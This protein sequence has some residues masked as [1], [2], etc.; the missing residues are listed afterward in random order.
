[1]SNTPRA[2]LGRFSVITIDQAVAGGSN[3][4]IAVLAARILGVESFALF[5]IIF[6]VY[7]LAQ[8][9]SRGLIS[10]PL[11]IHPVESEERPSEVLGSGLFLGLVLGLL[12]AMAGLAFRPWDAQLGVGLLILA[13]FLPLL[14]LQDLGRYL[15]FATQRP[16]SALTLDVTW[17]VLVLVTSGFLMLSGRDSLKWF[18]IGW[19]ASGAAAGSLLVWKHRGKMFTPSSVWIRLTWGYSWRYLMAYVA[20]QGA[21]LTASIALR[22][23]AGARVLGGVLGA[24]LLIRPY[25]TFETAAIA[26]GVTEISR[27]RSGVGQINAHVYRTTAVTTAMALASAA[28]MV[29]LPDAVGRVVLGETW[30]EAEKYMVPAGISIIVLALVSGARAGLLGQ[31]AI[32]K[33]LTIDLILLP[34][35]AAVSLLCASLYGGLGYYWAI[36]AGQALAVVPLWLT[37]RRHTRT[38]SV[39]APSGPHAPPS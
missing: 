3:V 19:A 29:L 32:G 38:T 31:R 20:S 16:K 10:E 28:V 11:L 1:M 24:Q 22:A 36:V 13:P 12:V 25:V 34:T 18:V 15:A 21:V 17:L 30:E 37:F 39:H 14:V 7:V 27:V 4:F 5:G 23:I 6:Q 2:V 26:S 35:I 33:V 9:I 8:G